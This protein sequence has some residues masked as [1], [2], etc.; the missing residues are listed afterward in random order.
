MLNDGEFTTTFVP[1]FNGLPNP[2]NSSFDVALTLAQ[3]FSTYAVSQESAASGDVVAV[4]QRQYDWVSQQQNL[5]N[6]YLSQ[7]QNLCGY[8]TDSAD[9]IFPDIL[10]DELP[11]GTRDGITAQLGTNG[12]RFNETGAIYQQVPGSSPGE[13]PRQGCATSRFN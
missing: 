13:P 8:I 9:N 6:T 5:Q 4:L 12:L 2:G 10:T 3:S 11:P 1:F 7:L